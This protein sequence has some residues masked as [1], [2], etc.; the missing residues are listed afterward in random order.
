MNGCLIVAGI[1]GV[2]AALFVLG[3]ILGGN[4]P[5]HKHDRSW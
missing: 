5:D 1:V 3:L 4:G 2:Y